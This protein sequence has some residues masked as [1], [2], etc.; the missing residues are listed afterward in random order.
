MSRRPR[1]LSPALLVFAAFGAAR[2][3]VVYL[4]GGGKIDGRIVEETDR[5]VVVKSAVGD[6]TV[7]RRRVVRIER[8]ADAAAALDARVAALATGDA[9]G[10]LQ[11]AA[12][13]K[14]AGRFAQEGELLARAAEWAPSN[15]R[16]AERLRDWRRARREPERG[17]VEE[18]ALVAVFRRPAELLRTAHWTIAHDRDRAVATGL[19]E[20]MEK[21]RREFFVVADRLGVD[22]EPPREAQCACA[23]AR[24]ETWAD[25]AGAPAAALG[26]VLGVYVH[27]TRRVLLYDTSTRPE[28]VRLVAAVGLARDEMRRRTAAAVES[29][30]AMERWD[31]GHGPGVD[32]A[33]IVRAAEQL[34]DDDE[35]AFA[36]FTGWIDDVR[37]LGAWR[38]AGR[39]D[40]GSSTGGVAETTARADEQASARAE[41]AARIAVVE[42]AVDSLKDHVSL[43]AADLHGLTSA[44]AWLRDVADAQA[45]ELAAWDA[46][47]EALRDSIARWCRA[48][49]LATACHE[50]GHQLAAATRLIVPGRA[51]RWIAEGFAGLFEVLEHQDG[52]LALPPAT[53]IREVLAA[54][55]DRPSRRMR[56]LLAD[57][58]FESDAALAYSESSC[59]LHM[60]ATHRPAQF[61]RLLVQL[62]EQ[63][64]AKDADVAVAA[65]ERALG[66]DVDELAAEF[67]AY[68]VRWK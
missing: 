14:A 57:E 12:D 26:D 42:K 53:R 60:L 61:G 11:L 4:E 38:I 20:A 37:A 34:R 40:A 58:T 17:A 1:R 52:V 27:R 45:K 5:A 44:A 13:A 50:A 64:V 3:D 66:A 8:T 16:V 55:T 39:A 63:G 59:F 10:A 15:P 54:W 68:L 46:E 35:R 7:E 19:G 48:A 36:A 56:A 67:S 30:V 33:P 21:T 18:Q 6:V 9:D 49:D 51:P 2:A 32:A 47:L 31:L 65:Y 62:R 28:V 25:A 22:V 43:S 24:F 29:R 41:R 23:C